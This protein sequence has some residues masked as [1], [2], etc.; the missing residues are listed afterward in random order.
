MTEAAAKS[1]LVDD[2]NKRVAQG[3]R[4][5]SS[6][7]PGMPRPATRCSTADGVAAEVLFPDGVT[8]MNAPPFGAGFSMAPEG[9]TADLQWAGCV[10]HN[11]WMAE[12]V[13]DGAG[14]AHRPGLHP[15]AVGR[16]AQPS[17]ASAGPT[18]TGCVASSSRR[19][20]GASTATTTRA[21]TRSGR[22]CQDL[23]MPIH[24]HSGRRPSRSTSARCPR[25]RA[26]RSPPGAMGVYIT[27]VA[28]WLVRPAHVHALGRRLRALPAAQGRASPRAPASGCPSTCSS[29]S[30]ATRRPTTRRSSATTAATS[31]CLR[32]TTS[33]ATCAS[34]PPACRAARRRCVT[35]SASARSCGAPTTP[36]GGQ[37]A[38]HQGPAPGTFRGLPEDEIGQMLGG[39]A[40]EFYGVDT[41]KL[42]P[43]VA[44]IGPEK[45]LFQT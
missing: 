41:E 8:E 24:F 4:S 29:S 36:P 10:A 1:F 12:F 39:N 21:T 42:A 16:R 45:S 11:R 20:G 43:L 40:A 18:R 7:E 35:T 3:P 26:T 37:L 25:R 5:T 13:L 33:S 23:D 17:R 34:A 19:A 2:I 6:R 27:E 15:G 44:R 30:S 38:L 14:A 32:S 9:V 28:W 22:V 31:R